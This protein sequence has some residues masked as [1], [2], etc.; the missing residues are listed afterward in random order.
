MVDS[1]IARKMDFSRHQLAASSETQPKK[2][3]FHFGEPSKNP[4]SQ[5]TTAARFNSSEQKLYI[6]LFLPTLSV[7]F[8]VF[9]LTHKRNSILQRLGGRL[10]GCFHAQTHILCSD[11]LEIVLRAHWSKERLV[12]IFLNLD[13][14]C[15]IY[16]RQQN[17]TDGMIFFFFS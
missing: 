15:P 7:F 9:K 16:K 11:L 13:P 10:F 4:Y 5:F 6:T 14:S 2:S 3:R 8:H 17:V 12:R 1:I